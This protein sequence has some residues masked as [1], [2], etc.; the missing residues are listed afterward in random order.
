[1]DGVIAIEAKVGWVTVNTVEPLTDPEDAIIVV[2][3]TA[4]ALAS[5][6]AEI[7]AV[8]AD[9]EPQVALLLKSLVLPSL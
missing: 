3:P 1:M 9:D 7:V 4:I 5:P 2:V 8:A 6:E